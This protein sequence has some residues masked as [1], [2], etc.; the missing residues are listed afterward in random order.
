MKK[1]IIVI[2]ILFIIVLISVFLIL[3]FPKSSNNDTMIET[4]ATKNDEKNSY[5]FNVFKPTHFI[6]PTYRFEYQDGIYYEKITDFEEYSEIKKSWTNMLDMSEDDFNNNFM[7]ITTIENISML[8]LT[9][10]KVETSE[11]T[12]YVSLI[13]DEET[14]E[15]NTAIS[16]ILPKSMD[17]E[18]IICFRNYREDEKEYIEDLLVSYDYNEINPMDRFLFYDKTRFDNGASYK[19]PSGELEKYKAG[20]SIGKYTDK[21]VKKDDFEKFSDDI[22]YK[23]IEKYSDY[24]KYMNEYGLDDISWRLFNRLGGYIFVSNTKTVKINIE[25]LTSEDYL[26]IYTEDKPENTE[27]FLVAVFIVNDKT[28]CEIK[29]KEE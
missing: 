24:I 3:S 8:G 27:D 2:F 9:L 12:I 23:K 20:F 15:E 10:D 14:N 26:E 17:R 29:L 22:Y 4:D 18:N 21:K 19:L 25:K 16:I 5:Q 6:D 11:N 1:K 13:K 28:N 7:I